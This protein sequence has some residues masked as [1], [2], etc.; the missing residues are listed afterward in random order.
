MSR[1]FPGTLWYMYEYSG[2][3]EIREAAEVMTARIAGQQFV[4]SH[5]NCSFG[6]DYR[7]TG[8]KDY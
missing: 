4:T 6:D 1:F 7:L 8:R 2:D 3:P 5:I